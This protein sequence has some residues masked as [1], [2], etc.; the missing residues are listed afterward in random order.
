MERE[1]GFESPASPVFSR[2]YAA[3]YV[4]AGGP[5]NPPDA[6]GRIATEPDAGDVQRLSSPL[7]APAPELFIAAGAAAAD[8]AART[9]ATRSAV[10][11]ILRRAVD[12]AAALR[13]EVA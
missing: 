6:S 7:P 9:G 13:G 11:E 2:P 12:Q 5:R 4:D 3:P 1:K 10:E 8:G